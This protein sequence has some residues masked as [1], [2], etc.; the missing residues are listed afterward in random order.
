M[1]NFQRAKNEDMKKLLSLC[2]DTIY[3]TEAYTF[4][5]SSGESTQDCFWCGKDGNDDIKSLVFDTGDRYIKVYGSEFA[6]IFTFP[7]DRIMI[8]EKSTLPQNGVQVLEGKEIQELYKLLSARDSLSFDD[9][10]RYVLRLRAVNKGLARV[11]CL[12]KNGKLVSSASV[13]SM[14]EKYALISDVFTKAEERGKGLAHISLMSAVN[15]ALEQ[16]KTPYL[17]CEERMCAY[18]ERAGFTLY[19]KM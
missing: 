3:G 14:N 18:Y 12:K 1:L 9:E 2:K 5:L 10:R 11:F 13:S 6:A 4:L 19:G 17:R 8:Y 16:G 7:D 15:F